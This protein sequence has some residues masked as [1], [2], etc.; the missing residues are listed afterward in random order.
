MTKGKKILVACT[1]AFLC[2]LI[3]FTFLSKS[4]QNAMLPVVEVDKMH[5]TISS[6]SIWSNNNSHFGAS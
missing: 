2:I 3:V 4:I 6:N 1:V 5:F